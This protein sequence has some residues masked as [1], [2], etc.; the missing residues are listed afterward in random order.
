MLGSSYM[1]HI[2]EKTQSIK[3]HLDV[4]WIIELVDRDIKI[5]T[6]NIIQIFRKVEIF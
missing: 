2:E 5:V 6:I 3:T 1:T 4:T